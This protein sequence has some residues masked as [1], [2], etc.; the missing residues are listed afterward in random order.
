MDECGEATKAVVGTVNDE[1]EAAPDDFSQNRSNRIFRASEEAVS[2]ALLPPDGSGTTM[3]FEGVASFATSAQAGT[4][5]G[6]SPSNHRVTTSE[7]YW[8]M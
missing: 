3:G 5:T 1:E 7:T 8:W 4:G 6:S 2:R